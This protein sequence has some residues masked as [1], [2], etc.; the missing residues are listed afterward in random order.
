MLVIEVDFRPD[1][2]LLIKS[3]IKNMGLVKTREFLLKEGERE[4]FINV[5][6]KKAMNTNE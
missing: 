3:F 6:M 4:S 2:I 1:Y 5:I